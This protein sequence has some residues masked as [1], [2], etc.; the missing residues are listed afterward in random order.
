MTSVAYLPVAAGG[1]KH[2][3]QGSL[4]EGPRDQVQKSRRC[5]TK[6]CKVL[7]SKKGRRRLAAND[8]SFCFQSGA[9]TTAISIERCASVLCALRVITA[10]AFT[11]GS[12]PTSAQF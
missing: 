8:P 4:L 7:G 1:P 6:V 3:G 12:K 10:M 11:I 2:T 9:A 5:G